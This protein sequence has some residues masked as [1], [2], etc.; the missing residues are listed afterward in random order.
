MARYVDE[1]SHATGEML[2]AAV[3]DG[4]PGAPA[5][6]EH[7]GHHRLRRAGRLSEPRP[8]GGPG[9]RREPAPRRGH[10]DVPRQGRGPGPLPGVRPVD[11]RVSAAPG[12]DG[13]G[14]PVRVGARRAA[15][16]LPARRVAADGHRRGC[17]GAAALG[18]PATRAGLA[19]RLHP[20]RRGD[21]AHRRDR[22]VG[23]VGGA[24]R[25]RPMAYVARRTGTPGPLGRRQRLRTAAARPV[26]GR[27]RAHGAGAARRTR[28]AAGPGDHRDGDD[29]GRGRGGRHSWSDCAPSA[30]HS[31]S[32]TSARGTRPSATCV[33]SRCPR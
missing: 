14:P 20:R 8:H 24:P 16:A 11:A 29:G 12:R 5:G 7:V 25:A 30:S 27:P 21:R 9:E 13:A 1:Q 26:T 3:V 32:T 19:P 33:A 28:G 22:R 10:G 2:A 6:G 18:P 4:L 17:R 15:A 31:R 23:R